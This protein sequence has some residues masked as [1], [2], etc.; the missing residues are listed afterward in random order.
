MKRSEWTIREATRADLPALHALH[1]R[2][3]GLPPPGPE[4][5]WVAQ[6]GEGLPRATLR[7]VPTIGLALPRW[8]YHV[9]CAV[10]AA[11]EL[12]LFRR[13]ATLQLGNDLTGASE[14]ADI[15]APGAADAL[16][17]LLQA[18]LRVVAAEPQTYGPR[19]ICELFGVR[20]SGGAA[21]FWQGLGRHF[22]R[23][24]PREAEAQHGPAW[25]SHVAALLPRHLVYLSFLPPD[26][27]AAVG[28]VPPSLHALAEALGTVGFTWQQHVRI[29]DGGRVLERVQP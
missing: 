4:K 3:L 15:A 29:E 23:T 22:Y 17:P 2:T 7:L 20:A 18:A 12:K 25:H 11:A 13:Q 5:L 8:W 21:P 1:G 28:A 6:R 9:G 19:L 24:D 10:H 14:L 16:A 26:A 27:Q